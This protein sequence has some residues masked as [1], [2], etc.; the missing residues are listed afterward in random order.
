LLV[1]NA[2]GQVLRRDEDCGQ[3]RS[4]FSSFKIAL[5]VMGFDAGI[6]D[7]ARAPR[8]DYKPEFQAS[9]RQQKSVDPSSWLQDSIVWYS[10]EITRKLGPVR[11]ADYVGRLAYGNQ[12]VSGDPQKKDGLTQAW[13]GSSLAVSADEQADFVR[14][15]LN[16]QLPVSQQA[17]A[18]T[19]AI[20]PAYG[21]GDGWVVHG[22]TGSGWLRDSQ[23]HLDYDRPLGWFVGW[24]DKGSRQTVFVRMEVRAGSQEPALGL[25]L[26]EAFLKELPTLMPAPVNAG[27]PCS[28]EGWNDPAS[29]RR[30][31]G[32][33]WYVGTCGLSAI[34][35]TSPAGHVLLDGD[36]VQGAA[37][38]EANIR[39]L[40]FRLRDVRYILNSH[41]HVD[42]AGGI[43]QLQQRSNA[44]VVA[45]GADADA[46]ERGG[47]DRTD[48]Q[49]LNADKFPPAT[50]VRRIREGE[51][52]ALGSAIVLTAHATPG[53][54]PG[55]TSWT[56]RS[57]DDTGACLRMAYADSI[58][59]IADNV[60]R[61][62]DETAHPGTLAGFRASIAKVAALPCDVLLTPH[63]SA[64]QL[65]ERLDH[66]PGLPLVDA[67]ACRRYAAQAAR[68]LDERV[69]KE[70]AKAP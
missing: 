31:H 33:T 49:F 30:I 55:S 32:N 29:P 67:S 13:L 36:T 42:H 48:P 38:V 21:A 51:T 37:L 25:A 12:D 7:S 70:A 17:L 10:Q 66:R 26:R 15:L 47:G 65:W 45:G 68:K 43:A 46:L 22:K 2:S 57:C 18:K 35:I 58:T 59:A 41:A 19:R 4:P 61:Y 44:T 34:L 14:R 62:T 39:Q 6:L 27:T 11:F 53:H 56:W 8:W 20:V 16:Q 9:A 23:G 69:A 1:D 63:P 40:G 50:G 64:S 3:R 24:A 5:A 52:L 54:T 28:S 60:Y